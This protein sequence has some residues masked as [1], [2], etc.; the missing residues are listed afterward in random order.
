[1]FSGSFDSWLRPAGI[2]VLMIVSGLHLHMTGVNAH[3]GVDHD[4]IAAELK[5]EHEDEKY[6][7]KRN[8][9][10]RRNRPA[11]ISPDVAPS[12]ANVK[13]QK[14]LSPGSLQ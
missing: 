2:I 5:G 3:R 13:G 1:M 7:C 11:T 9:A 14:G 4:I 10:E 6:G 12:H 8:S